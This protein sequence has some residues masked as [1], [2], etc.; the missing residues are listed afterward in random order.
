MAIPSRDSLLDGFLNWDGR[1]DI[2]LQS[3]IAPDTYIDYTVTASD[4]NGGALHR[5]IT[6]K[7]INQ[8]E[9]RFTSLNTVWE[10]P[11]INVDTTVKVDDIIKNENNTDPIYYKVVQVDY[12]TLKTRYRC[13]VIKIDTDNGDSPPSTENLVAWGGILLAWGP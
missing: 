6:R 10:I 13:T 1:Q 5:E 11:V 2:T 4:G 9:G 3:M 7:E 12:A 8:G